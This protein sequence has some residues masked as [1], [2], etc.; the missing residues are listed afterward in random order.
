MV[1][2]CLI[3]IVGKHVLYNINNRRDENGEGSE[4]KKNK[5]HVNNHNYKT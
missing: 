2:Y 4:E 5:E 3:A 1:T